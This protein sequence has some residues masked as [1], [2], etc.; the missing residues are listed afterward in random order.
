MYTLGRLALIGSGVN[1]DVVLA[2]AK[3]L[4]VLAVLAWEGPRRPEHITELL[5]P[6]ADRERAAASL[7]QALY[8]LSQAAGTPLVERSDGLLAL[9]P[10]LAVDLLDFREAIEGEDHEYAIRVYGG[11]FLGGYEAAQDRRFVQWAEAVDD[12]VE[13]HLQQAFDRVVE[14]ALRAEEVDRAVK[15]A[16]GFRAHFPLVTQ[17]VGCLVIALRAAGRLRAALAEIGLFEQRLAQELDERLPDELADFRAVLEAELRNE[18]SEV[19]AEVAENRVNAGTGPADPS[20]DTPRSGPA[21]SPRR[22]T[23]RWRRWS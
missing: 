17:A 19:G 22:S 2:D 21:G 14:A 6:D 10:S 4:A 16:E 23:R 13:V 18:L 12:W 11:H 15:L 7:R 5:W 8:T 3:P 20:T 1:E 9:D